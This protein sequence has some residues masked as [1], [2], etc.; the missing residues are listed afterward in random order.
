MSKMFLEKLGFTK[1]SAKRSK[2]PGTDSGKM[3][4]NLISTKNKCLEY[5][6]NSQN[7]TVKNKTKKPKQ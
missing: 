3:S 7:S 6:N 4:S 1:H 2:R 5:I